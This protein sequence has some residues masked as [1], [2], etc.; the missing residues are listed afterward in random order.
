MKNKFIVIIILI[1]CMFYACSQNSDWL[2]FRGKTGNGVSSSRI[3]PPLGIRWKIKLQHTELAESREF[4]AASEKINSFNPP[5]VIDDTIYFASGD[6]NFYALD[7][8]SGY[9]R[10]VF[11][12]GA[13]INS[14]PCADENNVYFGSRDG[15]LYALSRKTGEEV[16]HFQTESQ[17]NSQVARY[18]NYVIFAGDADAIYFLSP[19]GEEQF[20]IDNPGWYNFTFLLSDDVMYFGT[21]MTTDIVGP[22]N[23]DKREFL[24]FLPF[25]EFDA[26]L[27]S[28]TAVHQNLLYFGTMNVY[29]GNSFE[30]HALDRFSGE[31]VWQQ[32]REFIFNDYS[33]EEIGEVLFR[34]TELLDFLAPT[35]W[36]NSVIFT[37]GDCAARAFDVNSGMLLWEKVFDTPVASA[38]TVAAGKIYFGL[39]GDEDNPPKIICISAQDGKLLWEM[40]T[41]GALLSAPVIA[42]KRIIFGTDESVFYVLEEVF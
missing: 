12:S 26:N 2:Q 24:W 31:I 37:G 23:I 36:K 25:Y 39:L 38:A 32:E 21:G 20:N 34:N 8:E 27:Y 4:D 17:I 35:I 11:K 1:S 14:I 41:E 6:G 9:M 13:S 28:V 30:F 19:E 7:A 33:Y 5:I 22:F 16:W 29:S 10:W 3:S 40:E 42:G 15:K 18:G